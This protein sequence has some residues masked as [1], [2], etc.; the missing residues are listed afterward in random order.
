MARGMETRV[1]EDLDGAVAQADIIVAATASCSPCVK[2][3][4]VREG[5]HVDLVGGYRPDMQEGDGDL[6][7][8][9]RLFVDDRQSAL[10][11]G[12]LQIPLREGLITEA[13]IE[14]DLFDLC[15]D[16]PFTRALT[17]ITLYKNAG[18]A[19]LD[20]AVCHYLLEQSGT[21]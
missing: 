13:D 12:D 9:A 4:H 8:A 2:G 11:S 7:A 21:C 16:L 19:H 1:V 17:D 3:R 14:G 15:Q 5:T 6:I 18:G 20:L 10:N